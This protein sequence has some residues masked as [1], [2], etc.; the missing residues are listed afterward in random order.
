MRIIPARIDNKST[1][2]AQEKGFL[3]T[4][5]ADVDIHGLMKRGMWFTEQASKRKSEQRSSVEIHFF[6]PAGRWT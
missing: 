4:N 2:G 3:D 1:S 5:A 6:L